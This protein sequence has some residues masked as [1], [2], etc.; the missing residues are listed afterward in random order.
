MSAAVAVAAATAFHGGCRLRRA[1]HARCVGVWERGRFNWS[2]G[3]LSPTN[4]GP[5][6]APRALWKPHTRNIDDEMCNHVFFLGGGGLS[7]SS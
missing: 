3:C 2:V 4:V 6:V 7:V 5:Q 1:S